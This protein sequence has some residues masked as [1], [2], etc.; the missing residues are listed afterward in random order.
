MPENRSSRSFRHRFD[1][2]GAGDHTQGNRGSEDLEIVVV[3]LVL[4]T[5]FADLVETVKLIEIDRISIRHDHAM[6]YNRH[7][8]LLAESARPDL[9]R[10]T[11]H[12]GSIGNEHMLAVVRVDRA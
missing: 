7:A 4:Q 1:L 2:A 9:A 11:E 12:D 10:L 3:H 5:F 8:T 6:E